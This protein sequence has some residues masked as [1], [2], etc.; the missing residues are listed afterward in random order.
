[1]LFSSYFDTRQT[2]G[3]ARE[4]FSVRAALRIGVCEVLLHRQNFVRRFLFVAC[5]LPC[6]DLFPDW[7][8]AH[9]RGEEC[10]VPDIQALEPGHVLREILEPRGVQSLVTLPLMNGSVCAGFVGFDAAKGY[11][12]WGDEEVQ[13]LSVL[14]EMLANLQTRSIGMLKMQAL[15]EELRLARDKAEAGAKAKS[16]FLANMSH[17]IRTPLNA[18]LG[19]TQILKRNTQV[20]CIRRCGGSLDAISQSGEHLLGLVNDILEL[21]QSDDHAIRLVPSEFDFYQMME[22]VQVICNQRVRGSVVLDFVLEPEV[23]RWLKGDKGKIRQVLINLVGNALKF[24]EQGSVTV[25]GRILS[26]EPG[27]LTLCVDVKDTGYGIEEESRAAV[28]TAFEQSESGK[29]LQDGTGLG[30]SI[31]R[32]FARAM[33][34]D[35]AI[36]SSSVGEGTVFQFLFCVEPAKN[37]QEEQGVSWERLELASRSPTPLDGLSQEF[38]QVLLDAVQKGDVRQMRSLVAPL[39]GANPLVAEELDRLI[40]RYDYQI[41]TQLLQAQM[42]GGGRDR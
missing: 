36:V 31:S 25:S 40:K 6:L 37:D 4:H 26:S 41:L 23:P 17:E 32:R 15:N 18:V 27:V 5:K 34:G 9:R 1:L 21:V 14:A 29:T 24:T 7:V 39:F 35:V 2:A 11:R 12:A 30:L 22:T 19:H 8:S 28:F 33:G 13:L 3:I 10:F 42:K 20:Y 16:M 38:C